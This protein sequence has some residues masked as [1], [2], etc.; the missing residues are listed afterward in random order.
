MRLL[1]L[2]DALVVTENERLASSDQ[3]EI[4]GRDFPFIVFLFFI[5]DEII[6]VRNILT[7]L[8]ETCGEG[9]RWAYNGKWYREYDGDDS[10]KAVW[11]H[12]PSDGNTSIGM[13]RCFCFKREEDAIMMKLLT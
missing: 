8:D 12:Y 2:K 13:V 10:E 5:S 4:V 3:W 9:I 7:R 1:G 6:K 11:C